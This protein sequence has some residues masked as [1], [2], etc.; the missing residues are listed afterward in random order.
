MVTVM[1]TA[2]VTVMA[3]V[4]A[5]R[6][7]VNSW[8]TAP[9]IRITVNSKQCIL[10]VTGTAM[11]IATGIH[12]T[13]KIL[14][15]QV[16]GTFMATVT[17]VITTP[18]ILS[19]RLRLPLRLPLHRCSHYSKYPHPN[20]TISVVVT[21]TD[22]QIALNSLYPTDMVIVTA[23]IITLNIPTYRLTPTVTVT[24]TLVLLHD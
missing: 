11:V 8:V 19:C 22:I 12:I 13:L 10:P 6:I 15:Y 21:V 18:D 7:T 9:A 24:V 17:V 1:V 14:S 2:M 16:T 4:P 5:I 20:G 23:I 3:T